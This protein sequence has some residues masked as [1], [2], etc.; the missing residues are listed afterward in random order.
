MLEE[1]DIFDM[2][3]EAASSFAQARIPE[4]VKAPLMSARLSALSKEMEE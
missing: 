3:F 2:L 1:T 4:E